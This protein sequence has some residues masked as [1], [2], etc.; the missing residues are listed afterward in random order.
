[1]SL[2]ISI[3]PLHGRIAL[4]QK[5]TLVAEEGNVAV[6]EQDVGAPAMAD[7]GRF[8]MVGKVGP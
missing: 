4:V 7:F 2:V 1:M 6:A 5:K 3:P 8:S